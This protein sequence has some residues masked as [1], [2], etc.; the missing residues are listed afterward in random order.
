MTERKNVLLDK[1]LQLSLDIIK[2]TE[3]L[4][5][6]HKYVIAR[7]LMRSGTSIGANIHEAQHS[8]SPLDFVHKL[9]IAA[10][11]AEETSYW[12]K[13]CLMSKNYPDCIELQN[14]VLEIQKLLTKIIFSTKQTIERKNNQ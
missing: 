8:E 1:S 2:Y 4:E 10:K 7:Q 6:E 5:T 11:E 3:L 14:Q 13:L 9:K 12:I